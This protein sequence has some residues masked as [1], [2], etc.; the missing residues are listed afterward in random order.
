LTSVRNDIGFWTGILSSTDLERFGSVRV[1]ARRQHTERLWAEDDRR[2]EE[3]FQED[4]R[5]SFFGDVVVNSRFVV[6]IPL[7]TL[8]D[9]HL[10]HK[11]TPSA[12]LMT[13]P[14]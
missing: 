4:D 5:L 10:I 13:L 14:S 9:T 8:N 12:E 6:R 2:S 11:M 7:V 1:I 3:D